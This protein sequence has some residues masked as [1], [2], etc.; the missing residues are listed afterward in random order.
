MSCAFCFG[1]QVVDEVESALLK[2]LT[3]QKAMRSSLLD[4]RAGLATKISNLEQTIAKLEANIN[5]KDVCMTL[6][7]KALM[8][9]GRASPSR[10]PSE[11]SFVVTG[12][13]APSRS[14]ASRQSSTRE[15]IMSRLSHLEED[16]RK[17]RQS[18]EELERGIQQ[19]T[20]QR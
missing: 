11:A 8:L 18:N 10:A 1:T 20:G 7:S 16:L 15:S 12:S 2:T 9:D 13:I 6:D 14:G 3:N 4:R 5:D 17:T 19:Y